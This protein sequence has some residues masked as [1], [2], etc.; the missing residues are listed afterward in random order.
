[1]TLTAPGCPVAAE[2]PGWVA[3]A[4]T[5]IPGRAARRRAAGLGAAVGHGHDVRRGAARARLHVGLAAARGAGGM[6]RE[7]GNVAQRCRRPSRAP[8]VVGRPRRPDRR[9]QSGPRGLP[10]E[11]L[12]AAMADA[13]RGRARDV[14][15]GRRPRRALQPV[16][17]RRLA[18]PRP[19]AADG[20]ARRALPAGAPARARPRR[21]HPDLGRHRARRPARGGELAAASGP[22]FEISGRGLDK[23]ARASSSPSAGRRRRRAPR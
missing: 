9:H 13:R 7:P 8:S 20:A 14:A 6:V 22:A 19:L 18:V 11:A 16:P 17:R 1:M 10:P 12:D 15:L 2:M 3:E 4:I 21:R 23:M 5:P